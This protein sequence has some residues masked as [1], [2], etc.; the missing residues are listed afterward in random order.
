[1]LDPDDFRDS[2]SQGLA[3][4]DQ[5]AAILRDSPACQRA[6]AEFARGLYSVVFELRAA[7]VERDMVGSLLGGGF[8]VGLDVVQRVYDEVGG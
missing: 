7:G 5:A 1:M 6:M 3:D 2:L 8:T 4:T